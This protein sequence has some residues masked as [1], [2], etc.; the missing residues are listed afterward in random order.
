[1]STL[2]PSVA[3]IEKDA[4]VVT[5]VVVA[6]AGI[7]VMDQ[8]KAEIDGTF[9]THEPVNASSELWSEINAGSVRRRHIRGGEQNPASKMEIGND[10]AIGCKVP[11]KDDRLDACSIH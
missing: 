11:A 10:A 7:R 4:G 9:G 6:K 1:M 3:H 5:G 8:I 2:V